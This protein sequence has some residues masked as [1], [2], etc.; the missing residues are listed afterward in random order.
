MS[1]EPRRD[2]LLLYA[3]GGLSETER[4][5]LEAHL[6]GCARC[7]A[8]LAAAHEVALDLALSAG[9][10]EPPPAVKARL[11]ARVRRGGDARAAGG[12]PAR[13]VPPARRRALAAA[14]LAAALAATL[15]AGLVDRFAAAPLRARASALEERARRLGEEL[16]ARTAER[17]ELRAQLAAQDAEIGGLEEALEAGD[18][19]I[20]FL[21]TPGL[22]AVELAGTARQPDARAR[23]FWAWDDYAC[24]LHAEGLR[25]PAPGRVY[26][27]WIHTEDGGTTR[28]GTFAP[29]ARGEGALF[30]RLPRDAGRVVRASVTEEASDA[31]EAPSGALHLAAGVEDPRR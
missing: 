3:A 24:H 19:L 14:G 17:E 20:R 18:E 13:V 23:V 10:V 1:H 31:G 22:Q 16:D 15:A 4:A 26:A 29:D 7:E 30:A 27:L 28:V 21:R 11:L 12:P 9:P 25:P 8:E 6:R 5:D 2:E